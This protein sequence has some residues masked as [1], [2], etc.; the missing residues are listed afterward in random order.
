MSNPAYA[1]LTITGTEKAITNFATRFNYPNDGRGR[2]GYPKSPDGKYFYHSDSESNWDNTLNGISAEFEGLSE[3]AE[4]TIALTACFSWSALDCIFAVGIDQTELEEN[5]I[6]S[7]DN[8]CLAD[9]VD[10]YFDAECS[11]AANQEYGEADRHG[12]FSAWI[13]QNTTYTCKVC[14]DEGSVSADTENDSGIACQNCGCETVE[15]VQYEKTLHFK[16]SIDTAPT[17]A[18]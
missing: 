14:G 18:S 9:G 7:L 1:F 4:A 3:G 6:I 17:M 5:H 16:G 8:A 12:H 15:S 13:K 2:K 11:A 10:V